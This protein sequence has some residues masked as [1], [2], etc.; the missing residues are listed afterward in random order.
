MVRPNPPYL[1]RDVD[2][3]GNVRW[4]VRSPGRPKV[5]IRDE[6]GTPA[7][8]DAYRAALAGDVRPTPKRKGK[9]SPALQGSFRWLCERYYACAEFKGLD[10]S[11]CRVR[12]SILDRFCLMQAKD[13]GREY[14]TLPYRDMLPR[15]VRAVRDRLAEKPAAANGMVKA[16]R[17]LYKHAVVND[18][19]DTNPA[20][21]VPYFPAVRAGGIPAWSKADVE[22]FEARH[23][24]GSMARLA[25]ILFTE[26]GQRISDVHR[27]GPRMVEDGVITFT[28][29]KN[30]NRNP[31]TLT[32]PLS[33]A[34]KAA[35]AVTV[36]GTE[37]FLVTDYGRPFASTAAFGNK[38]R[39]WCRDA[40]L[41]NRSAHGLRKYFSATLAEQGA[42][43]REIMAFT[44][45]KTSKEVDRYTR[46][47]DQK[48]LARNARKRLEGGE[49]VPPKTATPESGTEKPSKS[50]AGNTSFEVMVPRRGTEKASSDI[51]L[52][53]EWDEK[54]GVDFIGL[55]G[56]GVPPEE[57]G[58]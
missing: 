36:H 42:S 58:R 38:F 27:L 55:S 53:G 49:T 23:P 12:R 19:A 46:S 30:R 45:H 16:L 39:D 31:V 44:G 35:L 54:G 32:L 10:A 3:H 13:G 26:F 21:V 51:E 41:E 4:Y 56:G 57:G 28:Q 47:A 9:N 22:R 15:H 6:Y 25:L 29:W 18:L 43:D 37:T 14:G 50:L 48:R 5:R 20:A 17:Q 52:R 33:D 8:W 40:G 24:M 11:T 34:L 7:F 1:S 2:R